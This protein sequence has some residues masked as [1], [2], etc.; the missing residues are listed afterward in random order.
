MINLP[1]FPNP[2]FMGIWLFHHCFMLILHLI[3][4]VPTT[5]IHPAKYHY[6]VHGFIDMNQMKVMNVW[7]NSSK[8]DGAWSHNLMLAMIVAI[9][10]CKWARAWSMG[11]NEPFSTSTLLKQLSSSMVVRSPMSKC[12]PHQP[13]LGCNPHHQTHHHL[14]VNMSN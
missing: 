7:C 9:V 12:Q 11:A 14:I 8:S 4:G 13:D 2:L 6:R 1:L 10:S 3:D 5:I